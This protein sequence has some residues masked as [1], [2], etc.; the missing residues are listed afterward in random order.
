M[1][2]PDGR[3]P[4]ELRA[5]TLTPGFMPNAEGSCL[6]EMGGTK[7]ICSASIEEGVPRW[8]LGRGQGWVTAEYAMLPRATNER[9]P[10]EVNKGRPSGRTQEIQRL[11]GRSLRSVVD[12]T[13]LGE[14][15]VWV[16]CDVLQADG[17]TRTASIT[18]AYVALAEALAKARPNDAGAALISTVSAVSVGIVGGVPCLDLNY[19]EDST[20]QVDM[21]VVMT[22]A[23]QLVEVQGT[24][25]QGAFDRAELDILLDLAADGIKQLTQHQE[26]VLA[27]LTPTPNG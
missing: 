10:R 24:A 6:A 18:G 20:A 25:E 12:M 8:L 2:R 7:V 27:G 17:G 26:K 9:V 19:A 23:G 15:T 3:A 11:I 4:E 22:G 5:V 14:I 21:N 1:T 16:D 13:K